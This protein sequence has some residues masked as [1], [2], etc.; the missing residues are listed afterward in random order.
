MQQ[1]SSAL[2][3]LQIKYDKI[4]L[5][6]LKKNHHPGQCCLQVSLFFHLRQLYNCNT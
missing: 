1:T 3:Q 5:D 6:Q 2:F 4:L